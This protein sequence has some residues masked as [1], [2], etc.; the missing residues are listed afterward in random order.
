LRKG[1]KLALSSYGRLART[2]QAIIIVSVVTP[3]G[4]QSHNRNA[5]TID[6]L[7]SFARIREH[8]DGDAKFGAMRPSMGK[9]IVIF[10]PTV[11]QGLL[12]FLVC[13]DG[14]LNKKIYQDVSARLRS[15]DGFSQL[16][17]GPVSETKVIRDVIKHDQICLRSVILGG[18]SSRVDYVDMYSVVN[19]S[20]M[21]SDCRDADV[22]N[23][24]EGA[25]YNREGVLGNIGGPFNGFSGTFV[26]AHIFS[27]D[28]HNVNVKSAM[29]IVASAVNDPLCLSIKAPEQRT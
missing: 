18:S 14:I 13:C 19:D 25:L 5:F 24:N 10:D 16:F 29:K 9:N 21:L 6:H 22:A 2:I 4:A 27:L 28:C 26:M 8:L 23:G 17:M 1:W 20:P 11:N 15:N 12:V 3:V 7:G